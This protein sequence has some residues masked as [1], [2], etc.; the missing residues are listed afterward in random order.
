[1]S[2]GFSSYN[3]V[4]LARLHCRRDTGRL[5]HSPT[6]S[7]NLLLGRSGD[8]RHGDA[9]HARFGACPRHYHCNLYRRGLIDF[10]NQSRARFL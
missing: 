4:D 2:S 6:N 7:S 9:H 10:F 1:M 5:A 3:S 8:D